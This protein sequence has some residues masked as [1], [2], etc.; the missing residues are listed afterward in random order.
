M[1]HIVIVVSHEAERLY[2]PVRC[3]QAEPCRAIGGEEHFAA[4]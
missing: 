4:E 2:R 1:D 3:V